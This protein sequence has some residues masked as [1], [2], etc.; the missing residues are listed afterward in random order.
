MFGVDAA[1]VSRMS[2]R[3]WA[4]GRKGGRVGRNVGG[5]ESIKETCRGANMGA[6]TVAEL[7]SYSIEM[8]RTRTGLW[9]VEFGSALHVQRGERQK[10][11]K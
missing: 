11:G 2:M 9:D 3:G 5:V 8:Q 6:F 10:H 1:A 7:L 4:E